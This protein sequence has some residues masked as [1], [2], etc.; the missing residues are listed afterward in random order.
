MNI[1]TPA[2]VNDAVGESV[3][4]SV[5]IFFGDFVVGGS[6]F[7]GDSVVG[8]CVFFGD[9]VVGDIVVGDFVGGAIGGGAVGAVKGTCEQDPNSVSK[10]LPKFPSPS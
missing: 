6:V 8:D 9:I 4:D 10:L 5:R 7:F 1:P 2:I 3:G